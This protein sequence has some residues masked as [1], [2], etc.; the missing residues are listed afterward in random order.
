MF[1]DTLLQEEQYNIEQKLND[2]SM[3]SFLLDVTSYSSLDE[4]FE[5]LSDAHLNFYTDNQDI[6]EKALYNMNFDIVESSEDPG[7]TGWSPDTDEV[8]YKTI[9]YKGNIITLVW[10]PELRTWFPTVRFRSIVQALKHGKSQIDDL[11]I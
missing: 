1:K 4:A 3:D 6:I 5:N 7:Y 8:K 10:E 11:N 2:I 9:K